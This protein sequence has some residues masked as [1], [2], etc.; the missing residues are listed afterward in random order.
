LDN[1]PSQEQS[2]LEAF[3][4]GEVIKK[5]ARRDKNASILSYNLCLSIFAHQQNAFMN[6][7]EQVLA[8]AAS[9]ASGYIVEQVP[10]M[11]CFHNLEHTA[12]VVASAKAIASGYQ[13]P[14]REISLLTL[15]AWFHDTGYDHGPLDHEA[16][17]IVHAT[18]FLKDKIAAA[19]LAVVTGCIEA[20]CMPQSPD[21][22]L[23]QILCDAD[24][25]HLG[26]KQYW[27][28]NS[29]LRQEFALSRNTIMTDLDW[30]N[31]E[32]KFLTNHEYFTPIAQ[33]LFNNRKGKHLQQLVK[34]RRRV[35]P[36]A[37]LT[38]EDLKHTEAKD[39]VGSLADVMRKAER[40]VTAA[41]LGRGVETMYRTTY[42]TNN[43]LSQMAD[44]KANMMLSI[45]T[46]VISIVVSSLLPRL[47]ATPKLILPTA[48]LL[49]TCLISIVLATLSTRPK[50][51]EGK[52]DKVAIENRTANLLFFGNFYRMAL[53][54]YQ[55]GINE[56][57]KD[58]EFLYNT[59]T[60]DLY[61]LG[62]VLA[63]KYRYLSYCYNVFMWG[64]IVSLAAFGITFLV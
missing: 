47:D 50:I 45:N 26:M 33:E 28:S 55:W 20:T 37:P 25:S 21:S 5:H 12:Q 22:L 58:P 41:R 6:Q 51:T 57:I 19:D 27:E 8:E 11:Y 48:L 52:V 10:A 30:L 31:F 62:I 1:D 35:D 4:V 46:I 53:P 38:F 63:K 9:W 54:D 17:S 39:K 23:E 42:Q 3:A 13:L 59:M 43:N 2:E 24:L 44:N 64:M 15:A 16:R 18:A 34:Q 14:D 32:V 29:R 60:R 7:Y 61:F 56:M 40:D 49:L 36:D